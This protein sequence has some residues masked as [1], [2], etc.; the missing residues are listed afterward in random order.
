MWGIM[1][2]WKAFTST[3]VGGIGNIRGAMIG[4][5]ILDGV[6][7]MVHVFLPIHLPEFR[8]L[9]AA[10]AADRHPALRHSRQA[11]DMKSVNTTLSSVGVCSSRNAG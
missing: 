10:V 9:L 2:G 11:E 5:F 6:E 1:A 4:A 7:I 3:V 8:G